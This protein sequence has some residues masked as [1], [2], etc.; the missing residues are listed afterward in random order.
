MDP[1][2]VS[3]LSQ[4]M[5]EFTKKAVLLSKKSSK[6]GI[7]QVLEVVLTAF[8]AGATTN[9]SGGWWKPAS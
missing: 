7:R 9:E 3:Q 2:K 5:A 6:H 1:N 8:I 4:E